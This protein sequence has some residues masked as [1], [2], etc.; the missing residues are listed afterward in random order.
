VG[1]MEEEDVVGGEEDVAEEED[2]EFEEAELE[3]MEVVQPE[4]YVAPLA[5]AKPVGSKKRKIVHRT[6]TGRRKGKLQND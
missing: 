3:V 1:A 2:V 4:A 6:R 5:R